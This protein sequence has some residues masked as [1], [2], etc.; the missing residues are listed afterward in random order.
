ME[1][2]RASEVDGFTD[3][4]MVFRMPAA[5]DVTSSADALLAA[6]PGFTVL[7]EVPGSRHAVET[8]IG[9]GLRTSMTVDATGGSPSRQEHLFVDRG[10]GTVVWL[11][12]TGPRGDEQRPGLVDSM[13]AG[14]GAAR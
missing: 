3:S 5:G 8:P 14:L 4:V 2:V 9:P 10:D 7:T 13:G 11:F 1:R 12:G 6:M